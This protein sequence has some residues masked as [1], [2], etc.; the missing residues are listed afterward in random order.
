MSRK[1]SQELLNKIIERQE[2][3]NIKGAAVL[4]KNIPDNDEKG[5]MD[6]RYYSDMKKPIALMKF[7]PK[8]LFKMDTSPKSIARLRKMFGGIKSIPIVTKKIDIIHDTVKAADG[9]KIPIRIYKSE[10]VKENAPILYYI[11]GGGFFG[12]STDVVEELVKLIVEKT[13]ILAVSVDYRL[14]PE[15]PYPAGHEDCYSVLKWIYGKAESL[16]GNINENCKFK[17]R[18][19]IWYSLSCT[20]LCYLYFI[21]SSIS[22]YPSRI[23]IKPILYIFYHRWSH[24][25]YAAPLR[26][27]PS[28]QFV[29]ILICTPFP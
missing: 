8:R 28:D 2:I 5:I 1:Y 9:Y 10:T 29:C 18:V 14:G 19:N 12:G 17:C 26:Y 11:H 6:P 25:I 22:Q 4:V 15:N 16:G 3:V 27:K 21:W 20:M 23:I 24:I 7:I 13:D